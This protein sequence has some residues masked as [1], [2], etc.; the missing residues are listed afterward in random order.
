MRSILAALRSLVLPAGATSGQRIVLDG[1]NGLISVYDSSGDLRLQIQPSNPELI[2]YDTDGNLLASI[3]DTPDD[4]AG[5]FAVQVPP[6]SPTALAMSVQQQGDTGL[7]FAVDAT[8]DLVYGDGTNTLGTTVGLLRSTSPLR[9]AISKGLSV[10]DDITWGGAT[11]ASFTP[12]WRS[13]SGTDPTPGNSVIES[14]YKVYGRMVHYY[15]YIK[16]GS[17]A[18]NGTGNYAIEMPHAGI[19]RFANQ[20]MWPIGTAWLRDDSASGT[21]HGFCFVDEGDNTQL[22]ITGFTGPGT[23]GL[24]SATAPFTPAT[25]DFIG[26]N[27][28]YERSNTVIGP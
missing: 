7:R 27:V 28:V 19:V 4:G 21:W 24:W 1:V 8:G 13:S 9:L 5:I 23:S 10:A 11:Y 25:D 26:W 3:S 15:G 14:A 17:T 20:E 18:S 22:Q 12:E 2:V 6:A 16:R